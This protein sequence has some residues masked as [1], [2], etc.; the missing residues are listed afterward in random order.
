MFSLA[1][2]AGCAKGDRHRH[3]Q[4]LLCLKFAGYMEPIRHRCTVGKPEKTNA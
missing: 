4:L 1:A 2:V 3:Y